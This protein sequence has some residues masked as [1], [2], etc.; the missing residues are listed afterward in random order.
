VAV[1]AGLGDRV[2]EFSERYVRQTKGRWAGAPLSLEGWQRELLDEL[3]LTDENGGLVYREALIGVPRKNGKAL[4]LDTAIPTPDGWVTM[5]EVHP[6]D[7]VFGPD[8]RATLVVA[9]SEVDHEADCY[10][11][12]FS[13]GT[14]VVA[15][16]RHLWLTDDRG[17]EHRAGRARVAHPERRLGVR[18]TSEIA[19]TVAGRNGK[20][21]R[22]PVAAAL[23]LPDADL[24]LDPYTLGVWLGDGHTAC[25]RVTNGDSEVWDALPFDL[26]PPTAQGMT[27]TV[28]GLQQVLREMGLLG[29]KGIPNEYL[30][31]S[32]RQRIALLRGLMDTDGTISAR[33]SC[34]FD[35]TDLRLIEG[36]RELVLTLGWKPSVQQRRATLYGRD[37]GPKWTVR[38]TAYSD[39]PV[40]TIPRKVARQK[41][42]PI[43]RTRSQVRCIVAVE[44]VERRPMKCIQ[45]DRPDGLYLVSRGLVTTHNSTLA[46]A[47]AL[48]GLM[49]A[50]EP[51]AEVYAAAASRDQARVVFDQ[52]RSF[53]EAS[54]LLSDWLTPMR[55]VITCPSTGGVFRVLSSDA[56][57]Q[58][59][60]NP[61]LVVID[62]LHAHRDP[63]LYYAL[64]TGQLARENPMVVSITTAGFDRQ[65]ICWQVYDRGR[66]LEREGVEAMRRERFLFRWW[67]APDGCRVDDEE[68]WA[69]ANPSSWI[70]T[71]DLRRES[72]RLPESVFRRLHLNQWTEAGELWLPPDAWEACRDEST[73]IPRGAD[74]VLG[75]DIGTVSDDSAVVRLWRRP[76]GRVVVEA[77]VFAPKGDGTAMELSTVDAA[78]H[79]MAGEYRVRAVVFDEWAFE[80]S[81]QDFE[82]LGLLM[83]KQPMSVERMSRD[84]QHLYDAIVQ[85][86]IAHDGDP[87]LAAHV[88]AGAVKRHERGWRLV[89]GKAKR[90]IDALIALALAFSQAELLEPASGAI[91]WM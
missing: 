88:R 86:R 42:P 54:P 57:L 21:H 68:A 60:L 91:E 5:G 53:V 87:V 55:S 51:G 33:G 61:S 30:R 78:I 26:G 72:R 50:G 35:N 15:D 13:D 74:V 71:E 20:R 28:F 70:T 10:R 52:A 36:V 9:E 66:E 24:P 47:I 81:A 3:Y 7:C 65:S 8:G 56:P 1:Y 4:A 90:K 22:I 79:R 39:R 46:A 62:E 14:D 16:A 67:Q 82:D 44:P 34:E 17:V 58:H 32:E 41:A 11:V 23:N 18:T 76:D 27:R 48:Y 83:I 49:G 77:E 37:C 69:Q 84:S 6:G 89:K 12:V 19:V 75:V 45:V 38:F 43:T 40:F 73:E 29:R 31:G 25:G 2:A 59:G 64:T 63:E 80:R 85:R